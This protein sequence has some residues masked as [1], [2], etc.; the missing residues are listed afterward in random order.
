MIDSP[1]LQL[2]LYKL[3]EDRQGHSFFLP[4]PALYPFLSYSIATVK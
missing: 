1:L 4:Q 2:L 3:T